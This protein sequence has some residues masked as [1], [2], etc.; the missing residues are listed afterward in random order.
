MAARHNVPTD[1]TLVRCSWKVADWACAAAARLVAWISGSR[2]PAAWLDIGL[3][4]ATGIPGTQIGPR[5][6]PPADANCVVCGR[7]T[8]SDTLAVA[9]HARGNR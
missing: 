9:P 3:Q 7:R 4:S 6:I 1:A 8:A 2:A 5:R